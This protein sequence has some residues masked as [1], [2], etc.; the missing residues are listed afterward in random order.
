M[1]TLKKPAKR[2]AKRI[3]PEKKFQEGLR[4][5]EGQKSGQEIPKS[6]KPLTKK[7]INELNRRVNVLKRRAIELK[8]NMDVSRLDLDVVSEV[9]DRRRI[10]LLL[11]KKG[12]RKNVYEGVKERLEEGFSLE[13]I[14]AAGYSPEELAVGYFRYEQARKNKKEPIRKKLWK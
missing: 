8:K 7:T 11:V 1:P 2:P 5:V 14:L 6:K 13:E 3:I 10:D 9:Y 4:Y 12:I